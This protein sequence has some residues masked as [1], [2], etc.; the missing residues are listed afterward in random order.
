M[1]LINEALKRA[2][3]AQQQEAPPPASNLQLRPIE[4]AQYTRR[5]PALM[6]LAALAVFALLLLL[7]L[8][9]KA[10]PNAA[11]PG[12]GAQPRAALPAA[13]AIAPPPAP[14]PNAAAP[15]AQPIPGTPPAD[16]SPTAAPD[17]GPTNVAVAAEAPAPKP[18]PPKLQAI[19]FSSVRPSI[20]IN[21]KTLFIGDTLDGFRV[22]AISKE[23]ATLV[24]M[25][26]TNV[27]TLPR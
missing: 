12:P 17:S 8:R 20:M 18:V 16:P 7:V 4:P 21:G 10:P 24:G 11:P 9:Q 23:S 19:I 15:A 27:L 2:R 26:Q 13:P 3:K 6:V 14:A 5:S 1:S 22:T 25:D